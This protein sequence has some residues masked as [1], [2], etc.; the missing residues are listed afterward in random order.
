MTATR[1]Y[2]KGVARR[3]EI[4]GAALEVYA[5]SDRSGPRLSDIAAA[6][7]L[8]EAGVLHYF[9]TKDHLFV[10]ILEARD[11]AAARRYDLGSEDGVW[12]YLAETVQTPGLT[13]LFVDMSA[14]ASDPAH[15]AH[16]FM[17]RHDRA[18]R[19]L[20]R[21]V[22]VDVDVRGAEEILLAAAEGL[23]L[24]WLRDPST[25]LVGEMRRLVERLR[26]GPAS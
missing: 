4:L 10:A 15:P 5:A 19:H 18:A 1:H 13:K 2:P 16:A 21:S 12:G 24:R 26:R 8:T 9:D 22:M 17:A 20:L 3:A 14:A 25:D 7:G 11:E 6:V 23:Q